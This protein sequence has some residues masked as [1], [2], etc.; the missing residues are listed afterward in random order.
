MEWLPAGEY[1]CHVKDLR[2]Q[3]CLGKIGLAETEDA[4]DVIPKDV[5]GEVMVD[6]TFVLIQLIYSRRSTLVLI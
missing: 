4:P 5:S 3:G 1:A 2:K 6:D